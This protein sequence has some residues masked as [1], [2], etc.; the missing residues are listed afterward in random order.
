MATAGE[1]FHQGELGSAIEAATAA[2]K[3][4]PADASHRILLAELLLFTGNLERAD[5]LLSAA[6]Q[7][8]PE[9]ATVIAAMRQLIR[10]EIARRQVHTEGRVPDFLGEPDAG[11]QAALA[12]FVALRCGDLPVARGRAEAAEALR[13]PSP[14]KAGN[15]PFDDFR[16][17]S[18]LH[19]GFLEVLTAT[20]KYFW[21]PVSRI[22]RVQFHAPQRPRDLVWRR[23]TMTVQ[24]G[25]QGEVFIPVLY[26]GAALDDAHA[27]GRTTSWS[28][29][30]GPTRGAGQRLFLVGDEAVSIMELIG[31]D[32]THA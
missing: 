21:V 4:A 24:D 31:L 13:M 29:D 18:D 16:D 32:F 8:A 27:L 1:L 5:I 25:P 28:D 6:A 23:C 12:V 17:I 20:G 9:T 22:I 15:T 2:V 7:M 30:D 26:P 3:A 19:A 14:G 11:L 10:A